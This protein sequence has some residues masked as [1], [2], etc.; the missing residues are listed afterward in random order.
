MTNLGRC[1]R[2]RSHATV[3]RP[4]LNNL[5]YKWIPFIFQMPPVGLEPT[6]PASEAGVLSIEL[7]GPRTHTIIW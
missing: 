7:R 6:N 1:H 3:S 2:L 5:E 4:S